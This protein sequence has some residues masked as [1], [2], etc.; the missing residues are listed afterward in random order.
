[1]RDEEFGAGKTSVWAGT[2]PLLAPLRGQS[3]PRGRSS[4]QGKS[5]DGVCPRPKPQHAVCNASCKTP[6]MMKGDRTLGTFEST[7]KA[8]KNHNAPGSPGR[9]SQTQPGQVRRVR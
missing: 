4:P 3:D 8:T 1:M 2:T 7:I 6:R 9:R 5:G